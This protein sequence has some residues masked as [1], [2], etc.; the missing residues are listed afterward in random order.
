MLVLE[1][2]RHTASAGYCQVLDGCGRQQC[3]RP[4]SGGSHDIVLEH[5]VCGRDLRPQQLGAAGDRLG[6]VAAVVDDEL[7]VQ[8]GTRGAGL[9]IAGQAVLRALQVVTEGGVAGVQA[10]RDLLATDREIEI[11]CVDEHRIAFELGQLER[12]GQALDDGVEKRLHQWVRRGHLTPPQLDRVRRPDVRQ[13]RGV[14]G[15]I[16]QHERG[17]V[18]SVVVHRSAMGGAIG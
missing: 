10:G 7:E 11:I 5:Q 16:R 2:D 4:P 1:L 3:V 17:L 6:D 18:G 12:R 15:D 9:A 8:A 13:E 14:S